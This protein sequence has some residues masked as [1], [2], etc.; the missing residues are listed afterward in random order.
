MANGYILIKDKDGKLKY[1]KDGG[2][3]SVEEIERARQ[4]ESASSAARKKELKPIMTY[5]QKKEKPR[6]ESAIKAGTTPNLADV[7]NV[8]TIPAAGEVNLG[9]SAVKSKKIGTA[10]ELSAIKV[11]RESFEIEHLQEDTALSGQR[12]EDQKLVEKHVESVINKLKI[13][14]NDEKIKARFSNL[15]MTFFRGVRTEKELEYI[16][17]MPKVSGGLEVPKEKIGIILIILREE[18]ESIFKERRGLA[19]KKIEIQ[20]IMDPSREL[21]PPPPVVR[22]E[23][24]VQDAPLDKLARALEQGESVEP[25]ERDK[26]LSPIPAIVRRIVEKPLAGKALNISGDRPRVEN[27]GSERKLIGPIE[28]LG[29]MNLEN[30][31][32]LGKNVEQILS[33][34][35]EK[36]AVLAEQSL[37][38]KMEGVKQ[39]KISPLFRLYAAM[40]MQAIKE[41][42]PI[43]KIIEERQIKNEKSLTLSEYEMMGRIS[44]RL[45][46]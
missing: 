13:Q 5:E 26:K 29:E 12:E 43:A 1:Y 10:L 42:K 16:L 34:L 32:R 44:R 23:S 14:F 36:F 15:L 24:S 11:S 17:G 46:E 9:L 30:M 8:R 20:P 2:F 18:K 19:G 22:K 25:L 3:F 40:T 21:E 38:K 31:R 41:R 6:I 7:K 45:S 33:A 35:M 37:V 39:W 27:F 28:E 4:S